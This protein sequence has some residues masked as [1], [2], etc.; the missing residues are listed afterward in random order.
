MDAYQL[1]TQI[2]ATALLLARSMTT[3]ELT[4]V[5]LLFTQLGTTM[6]TIA[7]LRG[8]DEADLATGGA[9]AEDVAEAA[10]L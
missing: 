6:A 4:R 1:S 2:H 8:L 3:E 9:A 10:A 5:S 7:A